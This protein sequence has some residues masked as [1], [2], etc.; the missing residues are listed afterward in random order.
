[1]INQTVSGFTDRR[2][3]GGNVR[4]F[5]QRFNI[6]SMLDYDTQ[7]KA[8][9]MFTVQGTLNGGGSGTDYNFLLDRRRSPVL[10]VRNAVNGTPVSVTTLIQNGF[11]TS[12]L[13]LLANQRTSI[14]TLAQVGMTNHLNEKWIIGTDFTI[15]KTAGMAASGGVPDPV[16][17]C[18]A[19]EGCVPATPSS[20]NTW[21]ISERMTG[22]GVIQ[23]GDITNFSLSYTKGQLTTTEAFQVSNHADLQE[24]W[25][26][27]SALRLSFQSDSSGGK[28]NDLS[29]S[30]R[31]TYKVKRNLTADTQ[32]GLDWNKT[33]SSVLQSSSSSFRQF[34]SFG[35]RLDF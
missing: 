34:V 11:T 27:D 20:G 6:M 18:I 26:L 19:T 15:A 12:D 9:N 25:T 23:P 32:L 21:T 17:G 16:N 28:S 5:D 4:Y 33:S 24:K 1:M 7:F 13:I 22:M 35:F 14:S 31:V 8:L 30:V 2:A 10:D 3:V 29:P